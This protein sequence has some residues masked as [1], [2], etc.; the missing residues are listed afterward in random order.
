M[1]EYEACKPLV[2]LLRGHVHVERRLAMFEEEAKTFPPR[3]SQLAAIKYYLHRMLWNCQD[4]WENHHHGITNY[5]TFLDAID[6]WSYEHKE[7]VCYVTFNYDT[8]IE[9]SMVG[10]W[11]CE[12]DD[13]DAYTSHPRFKLIKLH[14]SIDW[15]HRLKTFT[16]PATAS[17]II[18]DAAVRGVDVGEQYMKVGAGVTLK[19]GNIGFPALAIPVEKKS[20]FVCPAEH[21]SELAAVIP[22]VTR[23]ITIGWRAT[24]QNFLTMLKKPLTGLQGAVDLM[25]VSGDIRGVTQTNTNLGIVDVPSGRR[26]YATVDTGF[27]GLIKDIHFLEAFLR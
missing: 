21:L 1:K 12:F 7:Q 3:H 5:I 14:G 20:E 27:S 13:L 22:K 8:M 10:L 26:L 18:K 24:E 4:N 2:N 16:P 11:G 19:D 25:V 9:R 15:G 6:R 23:I 17:D